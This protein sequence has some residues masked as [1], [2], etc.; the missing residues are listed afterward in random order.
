MTPE[1]TVKKVPLDK[2]KNHDEYD[3]VQ[4]LFL[5]RLGGEIVS[6]ERIQNPSLYLPYAVKKYTMK[7]HYRSESNGPEFECERKLFHGT[8]EDATHMINA[9]GFNR[10]FSG[11]NGEFYYDTH[12]LI[13]LKF[14]R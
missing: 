12:A 7:E 10:V 4:T 3:E 9:Q 6:I 11:K 13:S 8:R 1:Q 2:D 5:G 14:H